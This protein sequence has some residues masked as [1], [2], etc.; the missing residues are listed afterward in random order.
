MR[1]D[2]D[3]KLLDRTTRVYNNNNYVRDIQKIFMKIWL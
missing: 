1:T 3:L 2:I